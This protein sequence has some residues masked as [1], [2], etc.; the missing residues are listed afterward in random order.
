MNRFVSFE[1]IDGSGKTTVI[2]EVSSILISKGYRVKVTR[3][4]TDSSVGKCVQHCIE[5]Q[6][7]PTVTAFTFIS[8]RI[9]HGKQILE[10]LEHYDII[11]CD[12]YAEST[13]A[14]QGS[15]LHEHMENPIHWLKELSKNR[16]PLPDQVF[17]FDIQPEQAMK[18]IQGREELIPFEKVSFLSKV[19]KQYLDLAKDDRFVIIDAS[20]SLDTII[21]QCIKE[22]IT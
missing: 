15:Q 3:E 14:Y 8:D 16:F 17:L 6:A 21:K 20:H 4:P 19:R 5:T 10:W 11:L 22:I 1:G 13:Y 12:R 7:D 9:I 2:K 18:R